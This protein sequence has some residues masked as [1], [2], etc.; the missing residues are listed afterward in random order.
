M[1]IAATI[2]LALAAF[3]GP[4]AWAADATP[5][6]ETVSS[7]SGRWGIK[8]ADSPQEADLTSLRDRVSSMGGMP[9]R[10]F[11]VK[12]PGG[13]TTGYILTA[14]DFSTSAAAYEARGPLAEKIGLP[15]ASLQVIELPR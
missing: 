10:V 11:P 5:P 8:L 6:G 7:S 1:R 15:A 3:C 9:G 2:V 14:G 4:A 12:D 13:T